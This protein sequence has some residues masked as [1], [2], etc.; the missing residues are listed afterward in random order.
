MI[1]FEKKLGEFDRQVQ[2]IIPAFSVQK[3]VRI[4]HWHLLII[5]IAVQKLEGH[6][7]WLQ[8]HG[9]STCFDSNVSALG[10][11]LGN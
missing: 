2:N 5:L 8:N 1:N 9:Q 6:V 10:D 7:Q 11:K 3:Y 4:L